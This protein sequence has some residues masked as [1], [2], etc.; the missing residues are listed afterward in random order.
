MTA[1]LPAAA[2]AWML[3]G[4]L[5][6]VNGPWHDARDGA[7][8]VVREGDA[9]RVVDVDEWVSVDGWVYARGEGCVWVLAAGMRSEG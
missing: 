4:P 3:A 5:R 7:A 8:L 2:L 9:L 1:A 6:V